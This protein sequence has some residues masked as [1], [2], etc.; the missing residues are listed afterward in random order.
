MK[1]SQTISV[2]TNTRCGPVALTINVI[3]DGPKDGGLAV[4]RDV[5]EGVVA[6][7]RV[8]QGRDRD[9]SP[10]VEIGVNSYE[11]DYI[12]SIDLRCIPRQL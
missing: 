2:V 12:A 8:A 9:V 11:E 7:P 1:L 5:T 4:L 3:A 6:V 10:V